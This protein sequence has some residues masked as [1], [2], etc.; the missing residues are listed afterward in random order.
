MFTVGK[1][2]R[3]AEASFRGILRPPSAP[4]TMPAL[5]VESGHSLCFRSTW[6]GRIL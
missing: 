5:G 1:L 6:N 4:A 2:R 3:C